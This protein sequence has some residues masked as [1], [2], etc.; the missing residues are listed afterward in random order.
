MT[1]GDAIR[2]ARRKI[3]H[4]SPVYGHPNEEILVMLHCFPVGLCVLAG[5]VGQ[6]KA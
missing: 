6:G 1:G 2:A 3:T 5:C 4:A